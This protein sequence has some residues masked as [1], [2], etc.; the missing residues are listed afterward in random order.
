M[1]TNIP[2]ILIVEDEASMRD[3]LVGKFTKEKI[4]VF[5]A[6]DGEEG[7]KV[8]LEKKPDLIL[9]DILMPNIDGIGMLKK[10]RK[11]KWGKEVPVYMLTVLS[12]MSKISEAMEIGIS[13]YLVKTDW[14]IDDVVK[15]VKKHL[16]LK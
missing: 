2:K 9:L 5:T 10:L 4:E 15:K 1:G 12:D 14:K 3:A 11:D 13:G 6:C 16:G 7:L 8:A